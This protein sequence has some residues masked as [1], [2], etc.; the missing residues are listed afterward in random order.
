MQLHWCFRNFSH[1]FRNFSFFEWYKL[2]EEQNIP[3]F[4]AELNKLNMVSSVF[5][6]V[7]MVFFIN[8][9]AAPR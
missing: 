1:I 4:G 3:G 8:G 9:L 6:T 5:D 2:F 7:E